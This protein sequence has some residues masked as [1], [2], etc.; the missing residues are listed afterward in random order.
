MTYH[1]RKIIQ[2]TT[3]LG[4]GAFGDKSGVAGSLLVDDILSQGRLAS[5]GGEEGGGGDG[6]GG[7]VDVDA[8]GSGEGC[9]WGGGG[10][11]RTRLEGDAVRFDLGHATFLFGMVWYVVMRRRPIRLCRGSV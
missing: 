3:Y 5:E 8:T 11:R 9:D 1:G 7:E 10:G 6:G 4:C 2:N